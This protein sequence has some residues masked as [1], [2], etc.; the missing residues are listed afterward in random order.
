MHRR[1]SGYYIVNIGKLS[2]YYGIPDGHVQKTIV[3]RSGQNKPYVTIPTPEGL[4]V[5]LITG[6]CRTEARPR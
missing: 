1:E 5:S 4:P 3:L 2:H 6:Q